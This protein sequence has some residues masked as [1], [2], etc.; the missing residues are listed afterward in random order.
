MISLAP[1]HPSGWP[2]AIAPPFKL[3]F[4]SGH[5]PLL[6]TKSD[7][8]ANASFNSIASRSLIVIP[9]FSNAFSVAGK[10]PLPMRSH[11]T[12]AMAREIISARGV[13]PCF[14]AKASLVRRTAAAPMEKGELD[15]AVTVPFSMKAGSRE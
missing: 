11:S 7:W 6:M 5:S 13:R 14:F 3:I 2:S 1:E 9:A 4:S 12:P 8:A 10:G 15:A